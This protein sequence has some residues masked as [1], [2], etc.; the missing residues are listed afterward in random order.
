MYS[1]CFSLHSYAQAHIQASRDARGFPQNN[2]LGIV[3]ANVLF[4][5]KANGWVSAR[6]HHLDPHNNWEAGLYTS[7]HSSTR[8]D[9][10]SASEYETQDAKC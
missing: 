5:K 3:I 6:L 8:L 1:N 7:W 4:M 2:I 10:P 9:D